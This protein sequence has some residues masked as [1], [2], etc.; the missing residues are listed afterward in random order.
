MFIPI[1]KVDEAQRMVYGRGADETVDGQ[2]EI[3][4]YD[5]S[6]PY[7]EAWSARFDKLTDGKSKGNLREQHDMKKAAGK[8]TVMELDDVEKSMDVAVKVVDDGA[9]NKVLEGVYTG[10]SIGGRYVKKWPD[11]ARSGIN[12]VIIDPTELSL[13]DMGANPSATYSVVKADGVVEERAFKAAG[14]IRE[15]ADIE[16]PPVLAQVFVPS[17]A[18]KSVA[19][20]FKGMYSVGQMASM[21]DSLQWMHTAVEMERDVE[22]DKSDLPERLGEAIEELADIFLEMADEE[23]KELLAGIKPEGAPAN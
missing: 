15:T 3:W 10:F 7:V 2:K 17:T 16:A 8:L 11:K 13:V 21:L 18:E 20:A 4:D 22:G 14:N 1:Y 6:K 23:T 5:G 9:W 19:T 12:R